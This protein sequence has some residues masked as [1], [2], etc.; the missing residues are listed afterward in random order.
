MT[1][2]DLAVEVR[3]LVVKLRAMGPADE[4]RLQGELEAFLHHFQH[5]GRL[6]CVGIEKTEGTCGGSARIVRTRVPVWQLAE[7]RRRGASD[8]ELL[9]CFP[10]LRPV[11]LA[12]AWA[13]A[14]SHPEEIESEIRENN[15]A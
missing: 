5:W 13:Y 15:A 7:M 4:R 9:G 12:A 2:E 6:E 10:H 14:D 11:D 8:T 3:R 1:N